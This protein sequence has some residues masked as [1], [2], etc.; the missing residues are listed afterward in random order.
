MPNDNKDYEL[1][2]THRKEIVEYY[3][4][5]VHKLASFRYNSYIGNVFQPVA[6]RTAK[7]PAWH[8]KVPPWQGEGM[9]SAQHAG[10][11]AC[12]SD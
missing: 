10:R 9:D 8:A 11:H 6:L 7:M 4:N 12:S 2:E 3:A 1:L 5:S